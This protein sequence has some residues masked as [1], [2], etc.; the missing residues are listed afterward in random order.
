MLTEYTDYAKG[1]NIISALKKPDNVTDNT[2]RSYQ[3]LITISCYNK[4]VVN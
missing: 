4:K 1:P 2:M 3:M